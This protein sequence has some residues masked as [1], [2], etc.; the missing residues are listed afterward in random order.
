MAKYGVGDS[1]I[2][3]FLQIEQ[4][5]HDRIFLKGFFE[6][7]KGPSLI[8]ETTNAVTDDSSGELEIT[9]PYLK[10][11]IHIKHHEL[12]ILRQGPNLI[13]APQRLLTIS[14]VDVLY[15]LDVSKLLARD[16]YFPSPPATG[17]FS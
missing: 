14:P 7:K 11:S 5:A 6:I 2:D 9:S 13:L 1:K 3:F 15:Y 4:N 12:V 16:E 17:N 10:G 8:Y